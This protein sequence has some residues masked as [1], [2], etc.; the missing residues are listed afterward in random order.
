MPDFF[1]EIKA[2]QWPLAFLT[3]SLGNLALVLGCV[4]FGHTCCYGPRKLSGDV[5]NRWW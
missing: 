4:I 1:E 5:K 2:G 3:Y